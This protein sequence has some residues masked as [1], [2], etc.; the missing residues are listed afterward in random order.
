VAALAGVVPIGIE[1]RGRS[2]FARQA[3]CAAADGPGYSE[4]LT[5]RT[6]SSRNTP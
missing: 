3:G 5:M 6:P 2:A 4:W 1:P